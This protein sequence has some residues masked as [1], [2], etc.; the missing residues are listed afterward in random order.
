MNILFIN[1]T[2]GYFG[3]VEQNI[4]LSAQ[5]LTDL[6]H[7]CFFV[8]RHNSGVGQ[9][10]F[11][12]LFEQTWT[13]Q[14]TTLREVVEKVSPDIFYV[15]KFEGI[16]EIL[17]LKGERRVIR[18]VH[19]HDLYCPRRHKYYTFSRKICTHRCGLVCYADL[20]FLQRGAKGIRFVSIRKKIVEMRRNREV[21]ALLVGSRYMQGELERNG[22]AAEQI[23]LVPP[24]VEPF[25]KPL[26][27][28]PPKPSIL[29]VGQLIR[30]KGVDTLL[31]GYA[32]LMEKLDT[33][34]EIHIVGKGNDEGSLHEYAHALACKD[35][36]HFHGWVAHDD[37]VGLY[38]ESS[39]VVVPSRWPEPFGMV[40]V[41]AML[42]ARPVVGTAVGGIPDWLEDGKNGYLVPPNDPQA[43]CD[44]LSA[45][46]LDPHRAE[47]MGAMGKA[48][49]QEKFSFEK[50]MKTLEHLMERA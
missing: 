22:F 34:I 42:R 44:A 39:V 47:Q 17:A 36:V 35:S 2:G 4:A 46:V 20:A 14:A 5:G 21:D 48:L 26:Q 7:R 13:L 16:G 10:Q 29:Y 12:T 11:D 3:G 45:L 38:D 28:Y 15:H 18:M 27:P 32:R 40:G 6:G 37:L 30:G 31:E 9:E 25:E 41:E 8:C 23:H 49:A 33:P 43:L 19:D 1:T 50:Y 24:C